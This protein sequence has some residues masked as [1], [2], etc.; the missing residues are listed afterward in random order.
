MKE[1][2]YKP[3]G[4]S[5]I[6]FLPYFILLQAVF[7]P[8]LS[9]VYIY[10]I[11]YIPLIYFNF[12]ITV[13]CGIAAGLVMTA[14]I[15][16][17]KVRNN[18]LA[19]FS[20]IIAVCIMKYVQ[21]C[22]YIPIVFTNAYEV[23][24]LTVPERF[25][26]SFDLLIHPA[27]VID[28]IGI[29]NQE[30]VWS[31]FTINFKGAL[32][33]IVWLLE[34]LLMAGSACVVALEKSKSPFCEEDGTWYAKMPDEIGARLPENLDGLK[35]AM[36]NGDFNELIQLSKEYKPDCSQY[37]SLTFYKPRNSEHYYLKIEK[38]TVTE[39]KGKEKRHKEVLV[40]YISIDN[41]SAGEIQASASGAITAQ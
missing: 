13:G 35:T 31:I 39:D 22:V 20:G 24:E 29:I 1:V 5:S 23:L 15:T 25:G 28:F 32:L 6:S 38:V 27:M 3:S 11:Y 14:I 8:I 12:L 7:I 41:N 18:K 2:Y 37:L 16:L 10:L 30:G 4:K 36:E 17:G 26:M 33:T 34:F 9:I 21:W 19:L 40:E